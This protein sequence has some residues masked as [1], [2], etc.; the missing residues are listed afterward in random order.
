[1]SD[2]ERAIAVMAGET[3]PAIHPCSSCEHLFVVNKGDRW[4]RWLCRA[5]PRPAWHNDVTGEVVADPPYL[6]CSNRRHGPLK[7]RDCPDWE[8]GINALSP[9]RLVPDGHGGMVKPE[10]SE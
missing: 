4:Y 3:L 9:D 6:L 8:E 7:G 1:M 2:M 10:E 5:M